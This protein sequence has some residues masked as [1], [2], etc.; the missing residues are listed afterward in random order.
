MEQQL[1]VF[2]TIAYNLKSFGTK[3]VYGLPSDDLMLMKSINNH[4]IEYFIT[5]DQRNAVFMAVGDAMTSKQLGVCNIGKGPAITNCMTGLLEAK[6]Q[7]IPLLIIASGTNTV[8]YGKNKAFQEAEQIKIVSPLVKWC[9]R[10]ENIESIEWVLKKAVFLAINGTPGPVYIEIPEDIGKEKIPK[11]DFKLNSYERL[12]T[13]PDFGTMKKFKDKIQTSERPIILVGGGCKWFKDHNLITQFSEQLG[14]PIFTSASGRG[15]VDEEHRLFCGLGGLY[16]PER[17]KSC[18]QKSDL[19][20]ALGSKLEETVLFG[21]EEVFENAETIE[22]N[23]NEEDFN[24]D[25]DSFKVIGE[26]ELTLKKVMNGLAPQFQMQNWTEDILEAK[27]KMLVDKNNISNKTYSL[28]VVDV[29]KVIQKDINSPSIFVHE[30]GLQ[31]MWSYFYPYFVLKRT[32]DAIVPSEQTSLGFGCSAAIGVAKAKPETC[33]IAFV[34]DG[35]FNMFSSELATLGSNRIPII[36]VVLKNG[37]YGWLEYQNSMDQ[38]PLFL[39]RSLP[40]AIMKHDQFRNLQVSSKNE[41]ANKWS[42]ALKFHSQ[43]KTVIFEVDVE[44]DDVPFALTKIDGDFPERS[45]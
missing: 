26:A 44:P 20:I 18:I 2:E 29:L 40:L 16:C 31:D 10:V 23:L 30:N 7:S 12:K 33:V 3:I 32:Q 39:D 43:G 4:D 9:H 35:A 11:K 34:G 8:N 19:I 1:N 21:W 25:I 27:R 22:V 42:E 41:L 45:T 14:A 24:L 5:K 38:Q 28:R 15:S 36:Y 6:S 37:G 13:V 17:M